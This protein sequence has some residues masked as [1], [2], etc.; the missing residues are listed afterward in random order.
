MKEYEK[1]E[2]EYAKRLLREN[3][4]GDIEGV[5]RKEIERLV[6]GRRAAII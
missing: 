1:E 5:P 6:Y 3:T 4:S 2:A